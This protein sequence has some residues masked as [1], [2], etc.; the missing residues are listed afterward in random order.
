MNSTTVRHFKSPTGL[1][2][3]WVSMWWLQ[4]TADKHSNTT[5]T[6]L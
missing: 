3:D 5:D 1:C 4:Q 6:L 2:S